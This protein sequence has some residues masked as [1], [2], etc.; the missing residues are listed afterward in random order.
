MSF[1]GGFSKAGVYTSV[2]V[3]FVGATW[4]M[5]YLFEKAFITDDAVLL[6]VS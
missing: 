1:G 3:G 6:K 5:N 2:A 4:F